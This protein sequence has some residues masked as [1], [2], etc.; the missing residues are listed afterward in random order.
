[1]SPRGY[2]DVSVLDISETAIRVAHSRLGK[3]A[4]RVH[5]IAAVRAPPRRIF[6]PNT[7]ALSMSTQSGSP[8]AGRLSFMEAAQ[9]YGDSGSAPCPPHGSGDSTRSTR[10]LG[11]RRCEQTRRTL[12]PRRAGSGQPLHSISAALRFG[13]LSSL[14]PFSFSSSL[15]KADKALQWLQDCF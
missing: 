7:D 1:L 10:A 11:S 6:W 9:S 2:T 4:H 5:W 13:P 8:R 12:L 3:I 15:A 14:F